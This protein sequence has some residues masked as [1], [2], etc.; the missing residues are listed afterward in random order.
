[1]YI[2]S[3]HQIAWM[4]LSEKS[5]IASLNILERKYSVLYKAHNHFIQ[6]STNTILLILFHQ[7]HYYISAGILFTV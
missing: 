7:S 5:Y 3:F 6:D 4:C 1:M 2:N